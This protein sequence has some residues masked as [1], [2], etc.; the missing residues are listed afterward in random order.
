MVSS[1]LLS[2]LLVVA[3]PAD[4]RVQRVPPLDDCGADPSFAAFRV[5][6]E[7][8]IAR[9]D[10]DF[11]LGVVADGIEVDF[12]GGAGRAHF[13]ETWALDRPEAS[14]L[15]GELGEVLRLGCAGDG[16]GG[17]WM[18]SLV[19]A[20][21]YEDGFTAA[22]AIRPGAPLHAA[23]DPLSPVVATLEWDVLTVAQWEWDAPWQRVE[24]ADGRSGHVRTEDIRSPI[25]Y[26]AL[27]EPVD[28]R[29]RM[30]VFIAGD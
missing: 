15:W 17:Y 8:A 3:A 25:D 22:V 12:G 24:M 13:A 28:G 27:F 5:E 1:L 21:G 9:K 23:P 16:Q 30:T 18:P 19:M 20:E 2:L 14:P 4:A 6:L 29:W 11:L 7:Q 26:R 10:S